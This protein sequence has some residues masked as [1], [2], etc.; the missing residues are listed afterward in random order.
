M[1]I[2]YKASKQIDQNIFSMDTNE[3]ELLRIF[4]FDE[5][6]IIKS[7]AILKDTL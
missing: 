7:K 1:W 6:I 3:I 2:Y 4:D 5:E